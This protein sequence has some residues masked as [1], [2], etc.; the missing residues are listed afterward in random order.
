[1]R[2][3]VSTREGFRPRCRLRERSRGKGDMVRRRAMNGTRIR[4][5]IVYVMITLGRH[6]ER[7]GWRM[8][9][10]GRCRVICMRRKNMVY[11]GSGRLLVLRVRVR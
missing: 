11:M 3:I 8:A 1:M 10:C 4:I 9:E 2:G 7:R 6:M 5:R